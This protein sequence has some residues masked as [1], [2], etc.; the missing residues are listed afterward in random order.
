MFTSRYGVKEQSLGQCV[1]FTPQ[2]PCGVRLSAA[3]MSDDNSAAATESIVRKDL[4]DA[5]R[6]DEFAA[7]HYSSAEVATM[8]HA[9]EGQQHE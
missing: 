9:T 6:T 8:C 4:D 7:G 3:N 1:P 2:Q 5:D